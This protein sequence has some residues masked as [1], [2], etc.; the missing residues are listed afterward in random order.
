MQSHEKTI[1]SNINSN[2]YTPTYINM[3]TCV[4]VLSPNVQHVVPFKWAWRALCC[5][6]LQHFSLPLLSH[7][8]RSHS[9]NEQRPHARKDGRDLNK[10]ASACDFDV[11]A[12]FF[13]NT[14]AKSWAKKSGLSNTCWRLMISENASEVQKHSTSAYSCPQNDMNSFISDGNRKSCNWLNLYFLIF[15]LFHA[16]PSRNPL[17]QPDAAIRN[18]N[19]HIPLC[20]AVELQIANYSVAC[21]NPAIYVR[22]L[23][24]TQ[25]RHFGTV[26]SHT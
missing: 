16:N 11:V 26:H 17:M 9:Y 4:Y 24:W 20:T 19:N 22:I 12:V 8:V 23:M 10:R 14:C 15:G 6:E 3:L 13:L 5:G 2:P 7:N 1:H 18:K 21:G 25:C